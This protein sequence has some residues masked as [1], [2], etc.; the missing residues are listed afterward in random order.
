MIAID[1]KPSRQAALPLYRQIYL[2]IQSKIQSNQWTQ[3][4]IL[5]PQRELANKLDVNRSTLTIAIEELIADG[6][7][8]SRQGSGIKVSGSA[9]AEITAGSRSWN[10]RLS[11][12]A[13]LSNQPLIQ[14]INELEFAP[15]MIR[16]GTGELAPE[17]FP[18]SALQQLI[19]ETAPEIDN[20]GYQEPQGLLPLREEISHHLAGRGIETSPASILIVS[21]ALQALQLICFGLLKP[22]DAMFI[23]RPS[24]LLSLKLFRSLQLHFSELPMTEH[25]LSLPDLIRQQQQHRHALLYTIPTFH[26]PTG[27]LMPLKDREALLAFCQESRL[28]IIEDD[29]YRDLW[30]DQEPPPP[31]KALDS[32]GMVLYVSSLSKTIGPGLRIG[33]IAGPEPIIRRLA[34]LKMQHDYGSSILSQWIAAE[35]LRRGLE[36]TH[37]QLLRESL[38]LRRS[39]T[40][41]CLEKY[42]PQLASWNI[43]AG[44]FYIWL[45]LKQPISM[46][47]L[48]KAACARNLLLNPGTIYDQRANQFLRISYAYA[49]P[50]ELKYGLQQLAELLQSV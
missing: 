29:V 20:F 21:G 23:E 28:P 15:G 50:D 16:L 33:W 32:H 49:K 48:F 3:G 46:P 2:F 41:Q 24:Y 43:P 34:D 31:L 12:D 45:K 1:W 9:W 42:F 26:N 39:I 7:L 22:H 4:T 25:G 36:T 19:A 14:K 30:L 10:D 37:L 38:R 44:G 27:S 17:L 6:Y 13:F 47:A 11:A 8:T 18:R 5:P 35:W 40:R